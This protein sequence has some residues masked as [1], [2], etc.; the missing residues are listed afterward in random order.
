M[1]PTN[2]S[3][4]YQTIQ[5]SPT[6][7]KDTSEEDPLEWDRGQ[8]ACPLGVVGCSAP[9]DPH[10]SCKLLLRERP[11]HGAHRGQITVWTRTGTRA[12]NLGVQVQG[13]HRILAGL[14]CL[15]LPVGR[16]VI[17]TTC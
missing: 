6:S 12:P 11:P 13:G 9:A 10:S 5:L 15:C 1:F 4:N 2:P 16:K 8:D 3:R 7:A 17:D 14:E